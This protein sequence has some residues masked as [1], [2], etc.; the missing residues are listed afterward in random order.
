MDP[1]F[2]S[3]SDLIKSGDRDKVVLKPNSSRL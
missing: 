2:E 1:V 3:V